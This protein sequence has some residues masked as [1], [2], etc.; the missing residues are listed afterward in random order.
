MKV[1][2]SSQRP[3][4]LIVQS[5]V[6]SVLEKKLIKGSWGAGHK[7]EKAEGHSRRSIVFKSERI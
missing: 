6:K 1:P 4:V 2:M 3:A 7:T 5:R